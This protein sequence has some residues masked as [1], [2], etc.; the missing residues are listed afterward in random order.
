[1]GLLGLASALINVAEQSIKRKS[2]L[3]YLG[4]SDYYKLKMLAD[5]L[6]EQLDFEEELT[7]EIIA[8]RVIE[9]FIEETFDGN[10]KKVAKRLVPDLLE[11]NSH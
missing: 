7:P 11:S 8:T 9:V 2:M 1:M 6:N 5:D 4:R 3:I 10:V